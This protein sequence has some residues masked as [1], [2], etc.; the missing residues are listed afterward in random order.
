MTRVKLPVR[1]SVERACALIRERVPGFPEC[2]SWPEVQAA[3]EARGVEL[4]AH[5]EP[6]PWED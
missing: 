4:G 1:V 2:R 5:P 3:C 6:E